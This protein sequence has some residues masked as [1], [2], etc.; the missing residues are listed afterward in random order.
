MN[1]PSPTTARPSRWAKTSRKPTTIAEPVKRWLQTELELDVGDS[2]ANATDPG[3]LLSFVGVALSQIGGL[4]GNTFIIMLWLAFILGEASYFG[5]K[6]RAVSQNPE[7]ATDRVQKIV[8]SINRYFSIKIQMSL[9]TGVAASIL[10]WIIGVDF[11]V[12]WGFVAFLLNFI[13]NIGSPA[14]GAA[15]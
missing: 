12:L 6:V 10:L 5:A 14:P 4:M 8:Q 15:D 9:G 7:E 13:P 2:L 11:P 3:V 1:R